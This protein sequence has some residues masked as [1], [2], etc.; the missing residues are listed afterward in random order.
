[1]AKHLPG[2]LMW[3][4]QITQR[5]ILLCLL[6]IQMTFV[7]QERGT[8]ASSV[9]GFTAQAHS[10]RAGV[11]WKDAVLR[12]FPG[13]CEGLTPEDRPHALPRSFPFICR[14]LQWMGIPLVEPLCEQ[15]SRDPLG[16]LCLCR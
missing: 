5:H 9:S 10:A 4:T 3:R 1:M 16:K 8:S 7:F 14:T 11:P 15:G 13:A 12:V 2:D 6:P